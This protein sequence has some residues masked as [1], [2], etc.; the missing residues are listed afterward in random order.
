MAFFILNYQSLRGLKRISEFSF[1][2]WMSRIFA[3]AIIILIAVQF[4]NDKN[5]PIY[6][7]L[8]WL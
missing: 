7:F 8:L 1:F 2:Y 6:A 5:I 4:S 3:S